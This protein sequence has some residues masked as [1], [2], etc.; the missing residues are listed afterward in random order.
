M[1]ANRRH[2]SR[3]CS[4][5]STWHHGVRESRGEGK[6]SQYLASGKPSAIFYTG[7]RSGILSAWTP[8]P[9]RYLNG[10]LVDATS[11][12]DTVDLSGPLDVD[13]KHFVLLGWLHCPGST[14]IHSHG[15]AGKAPILFQPCIKQI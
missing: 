10:L 8:T 14:I 2:I 11:V 9:Y 13:V 15:M 1:S 12:G 7:R 6:E 3:A 5:D 4:S